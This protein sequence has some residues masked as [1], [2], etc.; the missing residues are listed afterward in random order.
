MLVA[1]FWQVFVIL[2][3]FLL[4]NWSMSYTGSKNILQNYLHCFIFMITPY[5]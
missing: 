5:V 3:Q 2:Y 4:T 1:I